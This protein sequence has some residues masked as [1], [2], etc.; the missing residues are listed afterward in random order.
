VSL[1]L[2]SYRAVPSQNIRFRHSELRKAPDLRRPVS[3]AH[4]ALVPSLIGVALPAASVASDKLSVC[5][6]I[7]PSINHQYA[8]VNGRRILSAAGRRYKADVGHQVLL[9]LSRSGCREA[10][11]A[12]FRSQYLSLSMRFHFR[13]P[14][15]RDVDGGVKITQDAVLEAL[16]VNDNRIVELHLFKILEGKD[17]HVEILLSPAS[18]CLI[19]N[20][21][22]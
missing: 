22:A 20:S 13:S 11:L 6:P 12:A 7:P 17:P 9:A 21:R 10:V 3:A 16:G 14:R 1:R 4:R 19:P 2:V 8:T 15:R 18:N 5:L